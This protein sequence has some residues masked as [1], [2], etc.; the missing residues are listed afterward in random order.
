MSKK[1]LLVLAASRY[2]IPAIATAKRLGYRVITTDNVPNNPGHALADKSYGVDTTDKET[3]LSIARRENIDGIIAPCT[4]IAI[5]ACAYVAEQLG[6]PGAPLE[7]ANLVFDKI[8]FRK[9]LQKNAFPSPKAYPITHDYQPDNNLFRQPWIMKPD[10]S[11]GSKGVFIVSSIDDFYQYLPET[12]SFSP[13]GRGILEEFIQG[14]QGTCAGILK[15][16]KLALTFVLDRQTASPPYVATWGHHLP[17][18]LPF[19][20]QERLFSILQE[21]WNL[22]G[23][24][25]GP[26]DCDFVVTETEIYILELSP[27]LGGNGITTLLKKATDFNIVEYSVKQACSQPV[28]LPT[29]TNIRPTA[30]VLF[31]VEKKGLLYYD[32]EEVE[33]LK[34]EPWIDSLSIDLNLGEP[35]LPFINGRHRIGEAFI[36][37]K[38][39][40]ELDARVSELKQRLQVEAI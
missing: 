24:T 14:F 30:V 35:V 5:P 18:M 40:R 15:Q 12:L 34:K 21:I 11:S 4:D 19:L 29:I 6:L 31:G 7:C 38:N 33:V 23:V 22:L 17:S 9:F 39:R 13:T 26:F 28:E 20:W 10:R 37:G 27:R 16:G 3:V 25:D 32:R 2:Q 36:F 8:E 1:T